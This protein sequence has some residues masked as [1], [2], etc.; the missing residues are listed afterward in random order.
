[1]ARQQEKGERGT[2]RWLGRTERK[3]SVTAPV[4]SDGLKMGL[5]KRWLLATS[6][7]GRRGPLH[8]S[9]SFPCPTP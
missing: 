3:E 8:E 6:S 1:M 4:G 2:R 9:T 5:V 7:K